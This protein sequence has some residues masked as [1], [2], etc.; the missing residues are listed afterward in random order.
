MC[1]IEKEMLHIHINFPLHK[2]MDFSALPH[3]LLHP[4]IKLLHLVLIESFN[5]LIV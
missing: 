4:R 2:P 5:Y 3:K 1:N